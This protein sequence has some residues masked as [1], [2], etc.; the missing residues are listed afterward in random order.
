MTK[1]GAPECTNHF[2]D[3][4]NISFHRLSSKEEEISRKNSKEVSNTS[5]NFQKS[6]SL[7]SL[8]KYMKGEKR[9]RTKIIS[10]MR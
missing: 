4:K 8:K 1:C 6:H 5:T 2:A 10:W 9:K 3:N 7:G